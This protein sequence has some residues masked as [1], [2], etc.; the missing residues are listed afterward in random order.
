MGDH[1][2][3]PGVIPALEGKAHRS[4]MAYESENRET[5]RVA[6]TMFRT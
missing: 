3:R 6:V 1:L 4:R 2:K 5:E